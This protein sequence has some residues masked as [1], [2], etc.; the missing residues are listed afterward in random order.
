MVGKCI[1]ADC[2]RGQAIAKPIGLG[3][4]KFDR[5]RQTALVGYMEINLFFFSCGKGTT[6][7][8]T[9]NSW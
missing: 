4:R 6:I 2:D 3:W 5:E 7:D 9:I 8:H 1:T